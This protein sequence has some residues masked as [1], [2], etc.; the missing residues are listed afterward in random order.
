MADLVRSTLRLRPDRIVVGEVRG[1][2]ALDMVKA[3]NTGHP[4]GIATVHANGA[5]AALHR[6]EQLIQEAVAAPPRRLIADAID[7]IVFIAGRGTARRVE[8]I[9]AV[10]G[11]TPGGD[12]AV[13]NIIPATQPEPEGD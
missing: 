4:G 1:P 11:L 9:V 8:T 6:L 7:I 2:E 3:W 5:A 13:T 10:E 12:Y